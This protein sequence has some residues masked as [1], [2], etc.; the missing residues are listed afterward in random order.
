MAQQPIIIGT[1]NAKGGDT[2]FAGATKINANTT[3]LYAN[4][5]T[6]EAA[7][8]ANTALITGLTKTYWFDDNDTL[9]GTTPIS[10]TGGATNT[11]LT[12]DSLGSF[13]NQYNPDSKARL[14]NAA[15]NKFDF[16]S[17]KTGDIIE[18]RGDIEVS[19]ASANQEIDI[20]MS[21]AEGQASPYELSISHYYYKVISASNKITFMFRIYMGDPG[22]EAGGSRFRIASTDNATIKVNG[23]FYSVTEV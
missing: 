2:L 17:L 5:A 18:F 12:N 20:L 21:L 16:T 10:H 19:T 7:I 6:N 15:T 3:E 13:T 22:T 1:A 14:W 11:Y 23:W 8:L 4:V 9:T